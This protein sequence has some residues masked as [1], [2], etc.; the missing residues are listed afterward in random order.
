MSVTTTTAQPT[1]QADDTTLDLHLLSVLESEL[2]V[3]IGTADQPDRYTVPVV[4]SRQVTR[5]ERVRIEDP[6]TAQALT[7][8]LAAAPAGPGLRLAV[9][10]RRLLIENTNLDEL[11]G[12]LAAALAAMLRE[13]GRELRTESSARAVQA[14]ARVVEE[15]ERAA[16]THAA[17]ATIRFE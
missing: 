16:A 6:A 10:D 11:R 4:F 13:L 14:E 8:Q 7:A 3:E 9:S 5:T 1:P 15:R 2:P 12:G 17:V